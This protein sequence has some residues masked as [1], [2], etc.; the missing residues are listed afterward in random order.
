MKCSKTKLL[1]V[2]HAL[3]IAEKGWSVIPLHDTTFGMCSCKK[4][5]SCGSPGKH[6]RQSGW[7]KK[8][9][10]DPDLIFR[11]WKQWPNANVGIV[12]GTP[13]GIVVFDFDERNGGCETLSKL[14]REFPELKTTF[15]V[16]TGG[17][18]RHLYFQLPNGGVRNSAGTYAAGL[19]IRGD[20]GM[21]VAPG[22]RHHSGMT[23]EIEHNDFIKTI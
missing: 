22:S 21:V 15:S 23:Y 1:P 17:G 19:D 14:E 6:P 18:G 13:S 12:T 10:T 5:K 4:K 7:T 20:N 2:D 8:H 16:K 9:T 11:W 3:R